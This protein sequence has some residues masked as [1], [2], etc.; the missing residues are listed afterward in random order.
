MSFDRS[1]AASAVPRNLCQPPTG[2]GMKG[3]A[4]RKSVF[5]LMKQE[6]L[7][8]FQIHYDWKAGQFKLYGAKEW[9]KDQK[10][11][12]FNKTFDVTTLLTSTPRYHGTSDMESLFARHKLTGYLEEIKDLMRGARH[13]CEDFYYWEKEDIRFL[14]NIHNT[15]L[16]RRNRLKAMVMG[17]I[18]RH[19]R[20]EDEI[21][22]II[23]GM[24][25]GRGMSY[26]NIAA[27]VPMGGCKITV[28]QDELDLD[29]LEN[30]AFLAYCNERTLN[31]AGPDMRFPTGMT[32]IIKKNW[33]DL[34]GG[35]PHGPLGESGEPT[36]YGVFLAGKIAADFLWGS[37]DVLGKT[38]AIQGLGAVGFYLA[39]Y[40]LQAGARIIAADF[41]ET[42]IRKLREKYPQGAIE[43]VSPEAVITAECDILAPCAV[44]AV[45]N[46]GNINQL[47]CK[48]IFGSANN[49]LKA[50]SP[51]EEIALAEKVAAAGILF[52]TDWMHNL[53]GVR[54]G[55]EEFVHQ[56]RAD[57]G[58]L[59]KIIEEISEENTR[60]NLREAKKA[61]VTPTRRA[62]ERASG[63][64]FD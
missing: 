8:H 2:D 64:L 49:Q 40:Y 5:D 44:G 35:D 54:S 7:T 56:D 10:W 61:G 51:E 60:V 50:V 12:D 46:E 52:Q 9:E 26:K 14:N 41:D 38:V 20:E 45:I 3:C 23:D 36:A 11:S 58:A 21:E 34:F 15:R 62:Y 32:T 43:V 30:L 1:Y 28:M 18:R 63:I 55:F 25:L 53:A 4:M 24:N 31:I 19:V 16:G 48:A 47:K 42:P 22:M 39:E 29:N 6:E 59:R 33:S 13:C 57:R 27:H 17:G 37:E